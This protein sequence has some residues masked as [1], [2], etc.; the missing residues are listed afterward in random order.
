M[1]R[2]Q[3][4][5]QTDKSRGAD[6]SDRVNTEA[7][8]AE[9]VR[10]ARRLLAIEPEAMTLEQRERLEALSDPFIHL[11]GYVES[12]R[13]E[14]IPESDRRLLVELTRRQE[15]SGALA[16]RRRRGG[17]SAEDNG[18]LLSDDDRVQLRERILAA[19]HA[20]HLCVRDS[21]RP[22]PTHAVTPPRL[23][24]PEVLREMAGDHRAL[25]VPE[26][27]IAAGAGCE[28][29]EVECTTAV[30]VPLDLPRGEYVAL[31]V[32]GESM[33][34]LIRSGDMV[35]VRVDGQA[36]VGTMVVARDPEHGYVVKEVGRLTSAWMEL[37]SLNPG[38]PTIRVPS[39]G[40]AVLG[41]VVLRWR[42]GEAEDM[43]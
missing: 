2:R 1:T 21:E 32:V 18:R 4:T 27:A 5:I 35:L 29:W 28:L 3:H 39:A 10:E 38:F 20:E 12:V 33:E 30:E 11:V 42:E 43:S 7:L 24:R 37:R 23:P 16:R 40:G 6:E 15:L 13:R 31:H 8:W 34:P 41:R 25:V 26:L 14:R 19:M 17:A 9:F 36:A 22:L